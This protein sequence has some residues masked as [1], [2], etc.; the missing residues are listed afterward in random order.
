MLYFLH[1]YNQ[2]IFYAKGYSLTQRQKGHLITP[3]VDH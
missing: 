2:I 3:L 1:S